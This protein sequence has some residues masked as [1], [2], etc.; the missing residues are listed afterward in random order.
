MSGDKEFELD[1][2]DKVINMIEQLSAKT[3]WS[4]EQVIEHV[5]HDY[6]MNQIRVIEKRASETKT[7][8]NQLVNM[9]FESLLEFLLGKFNQ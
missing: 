7:D 9:Q 8:I 3:G 5:I 1:F 2:S 4:Q 6:L